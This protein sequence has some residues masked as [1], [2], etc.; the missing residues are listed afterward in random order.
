MKS[1]KF[2]RLVKARASQL[3]PA[4]AGGLQFQEKEE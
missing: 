4:K 1:E 3:P 2:D